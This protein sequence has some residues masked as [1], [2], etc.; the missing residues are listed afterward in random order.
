MATTRTW[1]GGG[2]NQADNPNDWAPN[3]APQP[4]DTLEQLNG[5]GQTINVTGN[6]LAG[7]SFQ[8]SGFQ[9]SGATPLTMNLS[10]AGVAS[11]GDDFNPSTTFN[12]RQNSSLG[13]S[14][15]FGNQT[16]NLAGWR[17]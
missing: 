12:L 11:V 5:G 14:A 13:L 9:A 16:V 2:N 4:G 10:H 3:G 1:I 7:D 8:T 17:R 6:D 15:E